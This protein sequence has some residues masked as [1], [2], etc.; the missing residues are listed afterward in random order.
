MAEDGVE[1]KLTTILAADVVG[2]SNLMA[3]DEAG[4]LAQL[5]AHRK[6]LIEPKTAE[7][8]GRVVKLMGDG[9]LMEF[10]SVVDAVNFAVDVQRAMAVRNA[11][12]PDG[13]R[14][15]YR[16]GINIGDIIV[17]GDDIYGDGVNVAARL[18]ALAEPGGICVSRPVHT[19]VEGKVDLAFEDLGERKIKNIPRSVQVYRV[20]FDAPEA[21]R[22][23]ASAPVQTQSSRWILIAGG[24]VAFVIV[25]GVAIWQ[26]P[27]EPRE[28]PT[29]E[30]STPLSEKPSIAVLP[31]DDYGGD[32]TT[33]RLAKGV[34]ED[35]ITD[36]A[37][38]PEFGVIARNSTEVYAD[39]AVDPREVG[40]ALGVGYVLEGSIQRDGD[41]LRIT[42]QL[43]DADDGSHLWSERWDRAAEDIFAVQTEIA[44]T[45]ANRLGGGAGVIQQAGRTEARRKRPENLDAYEL[46]LLG[47]EK[48]EKVTREDIEESIRLLNRAVE[49]DPGLARAWVELYNA[50]STS[51][52]YGVDKDAAMAAAITAAEKAIELDPSDPE[53]H[54]VYAQS[55]GDRGDLVGAKAAFETALRMAPNAFEILA[56]Y[57]SWASGFGESERGAAMAERA[58][59]LNP[60]FPSWAASPFAW[61]FFSAGRYDDAVDMLDRLSPE[62]YSTWR[63]AVRAGSL[64]ALERTEEAAEAVRMALEFYPELTIEGLVS[65]LALADIERDRWIETMRLAGFPPC[66]PIEDRADLSPEAVLTECEL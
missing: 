16:I 64:A 57:A 66:V 4:T 22:T 43:I 45:V 42:A 53:A 17:E 1:R 51:R 63:W 37:R 58:V 41:R 50:H 44:E 60:D 23:S 32:A 35:I 14:V 46:Y 9:T 49:L 15:S 36:L 7:H 59:E 24:L 55:L 3:A 29:S 13:Q 20:Q 62:R 10:S 56:F 48:L 39:K 5:K 65:D 31:F 61:A 8:R 27:W 12:V 38:F 19:Q 18:E 34:T 52:Y 21:R 33:E 11:D 2:Y 25:T 47:T 30:T 6:E 28:G 54:T 40:K 26:R